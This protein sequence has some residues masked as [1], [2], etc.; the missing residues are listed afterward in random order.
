MR[1]ALFFAA[2]YINMVTISALVT[3]LYLGGG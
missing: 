1:F 2:E 3:T